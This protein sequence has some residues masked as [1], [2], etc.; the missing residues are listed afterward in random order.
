MTGPP[1][2]GPPLI[3][4]DE[5]QRE[6][7][8]LLAAG[9]PK[10]ALL[11]GRRRIGKTYLL[12]HAWN[13]DRLFLFTAAR[14]T[15]EINRTQLVADLANWSGE[16][17]RP[18]DFPTWRTVFNL[19]LDLKA[20]EPLVVVLDEFQYLADDEAGVAAVASELNAA[21]ERRRTPRPLLLVLS[22]SAVGTME[23]LAAGGGPLYGRFAWQ[24]RLR[25]FTYWH[26][27]ELARFHKLRERALAYG[28]FGGTPSYLAAIEP[29]LGLAENVQR[30][31]LAPRGEVRLLVETALDQEDGL[32]DTAKYR[33][34]LRSVAGGATQRNEIAQRAGLPNDNAL[35]DKLARLIDLGYLETRQNVDA[36]PNAAVRYRVADPAFRFH[37]RFVEP[38]ASILERYD[39]AHVWSE[40]VEPYL[41]TYMRHEFERLASQAYDR[42]RGAMGLPAVR[43]WS[44]WEG[45]DRSRQSLE[46]DVVAPLAAGG[47][48]TGAVKWERGAVTADLHRRH[49]DM[50]ERAAHAGRTWAHE[51]RDPA[52][53]LFYLAA[54][55]FTPG[56]HKTARASGHPI[57]AWS[58]A[59]LYQAP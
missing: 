17:I 24:H 21:W 48:M 18:D 44:R 58:L 16:N 54:G 56:F 12:A 27:D 59:E 9:K 30:L 47:V 34:I 40:N 45:T 7:R 39:P 4:R 19:L 8:D 10:L 13:P 23:A 11:T 22:G 5:E 31:L 26:A 32:R 37:Q 28:I 55:G 51:A 2:P 38:N 43:A 20:P 14:T 57:I 49:L 1:L 41:D 53:P 50:L 3:D 42:R 46:V 35:R 25:P 15:P 36:K 29:K 6:L 33:A 52:A